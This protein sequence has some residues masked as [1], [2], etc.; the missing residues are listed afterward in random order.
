MVCVPLRVVVTAG[1]L[2]QNHGGR[3]AQW[4]GIRLRG[5]AL[6]SGGVQGLSGV[7][8]CCRVGRA[9]RMWYC[10]GQR[11]RRGLGAALGT[12]YGAGSQWAHT[13]MEPWTPRAHLAY[14]PAQ[15]GA[16]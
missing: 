16:R 9:G 10:A 12:P 15:V 5:W 2:R 7:V 14:W 6:R 13:P 4:G 1:T 11:E 3:E 8:H